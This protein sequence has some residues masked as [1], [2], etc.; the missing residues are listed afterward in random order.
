[1]PGSVVACRAPK[2]MRVKRPQY[3]TALGASLAGFLA[4]TAAVF[5]GLR[6]STG[7]SPAQ[8]REQVMGGELLPQTRAIYQRAAARGEIDPERIPPAVLALPFDLL[9]HDLLM[10]LDAPS[11][12]RVHSI[13]DEVFLP[14]LR[15]HR[16][17]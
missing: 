17:S 8:F 2:S 6:A 16:E 14:L 10:S 3:L 7:L 9:R 1:M 4:I 5:S 11:A 13:V 15:T 12:E